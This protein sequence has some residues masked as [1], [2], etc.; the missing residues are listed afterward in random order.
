MFESCATTGPDSLVNCHDYTPF[1]L[2]LFCGGCWLWVVAYIVLL[3]RARRYKFLEMPMI[4]GAGNFGWEL[5]YSLIWGTNMGKIAF[6][7]YKAWLLLD[8]V[9][10]YY[11]Y[12][13]GDKQGWSPQMRVYYK[14]MFILWT[15]VFVALFGVYPIDHNDHTIGAITAYADN[16]LISVAYVYMI[17]RLTDVHG[18]S[19]WVA[20]L[21]CIGTGTNTIFMFLRFPEDNF[22]HLLGV[23]LFFFDIAY[24]YMLSL[25]RKR[26]AAGIPGVPPLDSLEPVAYPTT[27]GAPYVGE[28]LS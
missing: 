27:Q 3:V 5:T 12:T 21:K 16:L 14:P 9:I 8:L 26:Q 19:P 22:L 13:W 17:T 28:A 15:V 20:W 6:W 7:A 2:L 24:I 23:I 1:Q 18:L 11:L 4:A 25:R 10:V